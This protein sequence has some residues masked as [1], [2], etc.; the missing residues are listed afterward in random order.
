[1]SIENELVKAAL[2]VSRESGELKA[3]I[4]L[5]EQT[6]E[7]Q[8]EILADVEAEKKVL[9]GLLAVRCMEIKELKASL[10]AFKD[11]YDS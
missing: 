3:K 5:H 6:I 11:A 7:A 1:M 4:Q 9:Q 2:E 8:K 10:A